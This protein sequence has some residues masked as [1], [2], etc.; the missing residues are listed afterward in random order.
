MRKESV[1]ATKRMSRV[2]AAKIVDG[3]G[4]LRCV[5]EA[6]RWV[7]HAARAWHRDNRVG[8]STAVARRA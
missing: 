6:L 7:C 4:G 1:R 8:G 3:N 2:A 5:W